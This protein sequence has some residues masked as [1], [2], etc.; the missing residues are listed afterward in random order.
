MSHSP[1]PQDNA[2]TAALDALF[3]SLDR[4]DA[5]GVAVGITRHGKSCYRRGFG[6]ASIEHGVTNTPWTR[7]RIGSTSKHF[8]ALAALLLVEDGKLD[9]DAG[10]RRHFPQ[11]SIPLGEPTLRH[12]MTHTSGYRCHID[13]GYLASGLAM[14]PAGA[15][16]ATLVGQRHANFAPGDRLLYNNS[17]Y[18]LLSLII[19]QVSGVSIE[20][21][22]KERIFDPIGMPDTEAVTSD[23]M[24][25]QGLATLHLPLPDGTWRRGIFPT[26][27]ALGEG[28]IVST[29]DDMLRWLAH[30]RGPK[31]VGSAASWAQMMT[32]G[33]LNNGV[34]N[35]Y[36]L[37]LR[38]EAYRGV[39]TIHHAGGVVGGASQMLSAPDHEL[40]IVILANS[41]S[42][43]P[44]RLACRV[45]DI[46]LGDEVLSSPDVKARS[47][48]FKPMWAARFHSPSS[49]LHI[50][51]SDTEGQL[52]LAVLNGTPVPLGQ[53]SETL[54]LDA[55]EDQAGNPIVIAVEG[56][57]DA[58]PGRLQISQ[59]GRI[60]TLNRLPATP[61]LP[62]D[63]GHALVGRYRAGDL[64][65]E[66][67]IL[68]E[69][70]SLV[71]RIAGPYATNSL[72]LE[73]FSPDVF[74]FHGLTVPI[75]GMLSVERSTE[76]VTGF[77]LDTPRTRR[78][79]FERL[80]R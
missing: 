63:V 48:R 22:L 30:L 27:R 14:R 3:Q 4:S 34:V 65:A 36:S 16:M 44:S 77:H 72:A 49:G 60:Q 35:P 42:I 80:S 2:A 54:Q 18:H 8:A 55:F 24:I 74:G 1:I 46:V 68:F 64:D 26:E 52:S 59:D 13:L 71:L 37:G 67:E 21:F 73:A 41:G 38:R 47:D 19:E 40:D 17:G 23:L 10:V 66:A 20:R 7:M 56:L 28:A 50:G 76:A 62:A 6:L 51:F 33:Q 32:P 79:L 15:A 25:R 29:V 12:L 5:P 31:R 53:D 61:V 45:I 75:R 43:D 58:C 69:G 39:D 57:S 70:Q 11:L 9:I 78:L